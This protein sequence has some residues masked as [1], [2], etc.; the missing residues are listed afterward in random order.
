[1]QALL[2]NGVASSTE[3]TLQQMAEMHGLWTEELR[4]HAPGPDKVTVTTEKV[5]KEAAG[6]HL[7]RRDRLGDRLLPG[8][9]HALPAPVARLCARI[10][11]A[12]VSDS[13]A[14]VLTCGGL[15]A[16]HKESPKEQ[17]ARATRG[18]KPKL[19]PVNI[20]SA[21]LKWSF[22]CALRGQALQD[23]AKK[24]EHVQLGL[25]AK[26]GVVRVSHLF[27]ALWKALCLPRHC[28]RERLQRSVAPGHAKRS[29]EALP[30]THPALQPLL[31]ERLAVFLRCRGRRARL[32]KP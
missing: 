27:T 19:R 12:D 2:S 7:P 26:R 29:P 9:Q 8:P 32:A 17:A 30:A 14:A 4:R 3:E 20:G 23:A 24:T 10:G 6:P 25:G 11:S 18:L 1:M 15:L 21:L 22:K 28:L 5:Y 31:R 16:L 13:V